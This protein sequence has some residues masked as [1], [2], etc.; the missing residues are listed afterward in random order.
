MEVFELE[1]VDKNAPEQPFEIIIKTHE[2]VQKRILVNK[3]SIKPNNAIKE[4]L[5]SFANTIKNNSSAA[6]TIEQG[7]TALKVAHNI[8][9]KMQANLEFQQ[10]N[11]ALI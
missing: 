8:I 10:D 4:E 5:I 1:D 7:Y 3:P 9:E 2:G 11:T 6:V